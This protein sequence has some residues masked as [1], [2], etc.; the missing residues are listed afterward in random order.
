M[1]LNLPF[2]EELSQLAVRGLAHGLGLHTHLELVRRKLVCAA[3][4]MPQVDETSGRRADDHQLTVKV[5]PVQMHVLQT[6]A[7]DASV[8]ATWEKIHSVKVTLSSN[9]MYL[10]E[11][12]LYLC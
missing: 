7:F 9:V 12:L 8:K 6:P 10:C 11:S 5:L 4:L 1:S 3:L 2:E